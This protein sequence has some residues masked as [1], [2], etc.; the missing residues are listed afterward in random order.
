[1]KYKKSRLA[2][3]VAHLDALRGQALHYEAK[4]KARL[5]R[6]HAAYHLSAINLIHYLALRKEDIRSLQQDLGNLGLS[7]LGRAESHVMASVLAI[8]QALHALAGKKAEIPDNP[9]PARI[10]FKEGRKL[11][12][13]HTNSLLGKKLKGSHIRIMVTLPTEAADH[14]E[15]VRDLMAQGMSAARINCAHDD[16]EVWKRMIRQVRRASRET[17]RTCRVC[18]DLGGPKL[19]TGPMIPGPEVLHLSPQRNALGQVIQPVR[20]LLWPADRPWPELPEGEPVLPL[21]A[22]WLAG[23]ALEDVIDL[24]DSRG[25]QCSLQV[26]GIFEAG[27]WAETADSTYVQAGTA[28]HLRHRSHPLG[29]GK[30]ASLPPVEEA[31]LLQ[32]GDTLLLRADSRPGE[33]ARYDAAGQLLAPAHISCTLPEVFPDVKPGEPVLM[34]D[35]KI[36]GVVRA[37]SPEGLTVEITFA[38]E[39]GAKLR[40]DKGINFPESALRVRGLTDK[41]REDLRFV[42]EHADVVNF[43]FVN[44]SRDVEDLLDALH[45]LHAEEVGIILKIETR[46][47]YTHLPDILLTAMQN[48]PIG[49][50]LA[51]GDL[52]I[53]AG[54]EHLAHVQ[55]EVLRICEA[56]HVPIVWATQVLETHAKKGLAS[57]AEITDAAKAHNAECV[58][59]NKGPHILRTV[60]LLTEILESMEDYRQKT[61]P[62]LP[63]LKVLIPSAGLLT[64]E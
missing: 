31:I 47:G 24:T 57:R 15:M 39:G 45:E 3:L 33:P 50:M 41:D 4:Y 16:P 46:K 37:A 5:G 64:G 6:V 9:P 44:S 28:L 7:R 53:E 19:R 43:S 51:R 26:K 49:V 29:E 23:L 20:L 12:K 54:W 61:A 2:A 17:G 22:A 25:K 36:E 11:L 10:S 27:L 18:M 60:G 63:G 59:L 62:M 55:E 14:Y 35:G 52:A 21:S 58:M 38:K 8:R 32:I 48:H 42:V 13:R 40:A 1:M 56:A 30:V 34:N